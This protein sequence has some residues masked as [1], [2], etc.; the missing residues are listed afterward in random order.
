MK[1]ALDEDILNL[2]SEQACDVLVDHIARFIFRS[3]V[4]PTRFQTA[5]KSALRRKAPLKSKRQFDYITDAYEDMGTVL[6]TWFSSPKFLN[7]DGSPLNLSLRDG[8]H[9]L[10]RLLTTARVRVSYTVAVELLA[11]SPSVTITNETISANR[12]VFVVPT[13]DLVR[14]A[15]VIPRYL[16]TLTSNS[17]AYRS[18]TIKLLERQCSASS[19]DSKRIAPILRYIKE[20][21]GSF[22]DSIDGQ[23]ESSKLLRRKSKV[24]S[25]MGMLVFAWTKRPPRR[26]AQGRRKTTTEIKSRQKR[27]SH[28]GIGC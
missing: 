22:V 19:I 14:A 7:A 4:S 8:K 11:L 16:D 26:S 12:R 23:I 5:V 15:L 10:A 24:R 20:Q 9:S 1:K 2:A 3:G 17:K 25:E 18:N 6:S 21:G 13:L 28:R 27:S